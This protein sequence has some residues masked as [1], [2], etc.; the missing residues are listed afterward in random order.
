MSEPLL[1]YNFGVNELPQQVYTL[2]ATQLAP[3]LIGCE[4]ITEI[5][6]ELAGGKVVECEAYSQNDPASHSFNGQT[7]RNAAMFGKSG[8]LYVYLSYGVHYCL[9]IVCGLPGCAEA[10]L[11][12]A[13]EP[14]SGL[15]IMSA[16]RGLNSPG[17]LCR[18]PGRLTQALGVNIS[19]NHTEISS[20]VKLLDRRTIPRVVATQRIGISK[21]SDLLW[22]YVDAD[23]KFVSGPKTPNLSAP[24]V[25]N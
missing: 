24:R 22:R 19:H 2:K 25:T 18:G 21:A 16:R 10:V 23:S 7:P 12:R 1:S 17:L 13:L 11:L 6:G 20:A 4:I 5:D 3:R 14:T 15:E 8:R 9:N